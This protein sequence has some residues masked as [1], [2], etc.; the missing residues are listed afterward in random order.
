MNPTLQPAW[1]LHRRPF[2]NTSLIVE[3][4]VPA[5]GRVGA[6]VR[7]GRKDP[8]L[9]PF[10]PL[11]IELKSAGELYS[12]RGCEPRGQRHH[13]VARLEHAGRHLPRVAAV[14]A[15]AV[16]VGL[17]ADDPLHGEAAVDEVAV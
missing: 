3:L 9:A 12:F 6:V 1:L 7:G 10:T 17:R 13:F 8:L 11:W 2:R 5:L 14:V 4:F 16:V 15:E